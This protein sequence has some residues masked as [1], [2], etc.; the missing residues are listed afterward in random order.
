MPYPTNK[1]E[2]QRILAVINYLGK[3]IPN[4]SNQ[5]APLRQLLVKDVMWSFDQP[6]INAVNRLKQL[7]TENPV[8][9]LYNPNLPIKIS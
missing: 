5:T 7:V 4:L 8:L 3:F 9:K 2:L 1:K 6:Q